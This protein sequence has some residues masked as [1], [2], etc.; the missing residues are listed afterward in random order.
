M[1]LNLV[2]EKSINNNV[3]TN[4]LINFSESEIKSS[5][6]VCKIFFLKFKVGFISI[7]ASLKT[8]LQLIIE[9]RQMIYLFQTPFFKIKNMIFSFQFFD[10]SLEQNINIL[11]STDKTKII[12]KPDE[13]KVVWNQV[14]TLKK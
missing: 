1:I 12:A 8:V 13:R 9:I 4:C 5:Q 11:I 6:N 3:T 10:Y 2:S 14:L 7:S